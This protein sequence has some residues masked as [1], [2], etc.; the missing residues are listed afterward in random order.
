MLLLAVV[1][2]FTAAHAQFLKVSDNAVSYF[3]PATSEPIPFSKS[4]EV[5][6]GGKSFALEAFSSMAV[7]DQSPV[8]AGCVKINFD[9]ESATA[10]ISGDLAPYV[11][12]AVND[13]H[14]S[15]S[16]ADNVSDETCGEITYILEGTSA[17]GSFLL[18]GSYKATVELQGLDLTNPAGAAIDLQNGKR[19][20]VSAKNG[21][22]NTLTDGSGSQKAALYCKGHLE[23]KGKGSLTVKGNQGHAISAKEYI[24]VKNLTINITGAAKDGINCNQYFAMESGNVTIS[25]SGDDG[26]QVAFKDDADREAEDTGSASITGGILNID[27][28]KG[29]AAKGIKADGNIDISG[30]DVNISTSCQGTWD[31]AKLKTKASACLGAD[32]DITVTDGTLKLSAS[33]SGGKGISCDGIFTADGG[34][35]TIATTGGMLVYSNGSLNHNYTASADRITSD[36]KSSAKGIKADGGM[37]INGGKF[38]ITTATNNAEGIESK[39]TLQINGG[40]IFIKAYDD[41]INSSNNLTITGGTLTVISI[42]GD[43]IDSN[44]NLTIS[45]GTIITLGSGGAEQGLD[46]ADESGCHVYITGGNILSFGGRNPSVSQTNGSQALVSVTGSL[47][48]NT[49]VSVKSGN[50][51]LAQFTI[52][53]T[54]NSQSRG[55]GNGPGGGGWAPGGGSGN[56]NILI[57]T[58]KLANDTSYTVV[59]GTTSSTAKAAYT[60]TSR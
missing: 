18:N 59:N 2:S 54:Y 40:E 10:L 26:I 7:V 3:F 19:I 6:I 46:A 12:V 55:P 58:A 35:I 48:A 17:N 24:T 21:T 36:Y 25:G 52:P 32:G 8:E 13:A 15:I 56:G 16:Q 22:V 57:S 28:A 47:T 29:E 51:T 1:A 43:G 38:H 20:A 49:T 60:L 37:V 50:E 33:G 34:D 9:G 27:I 45:G 5:T 41:G 23:L 44:A 4:G 53:S 39:K 30:G 31:T 42:V 11:D 14:I